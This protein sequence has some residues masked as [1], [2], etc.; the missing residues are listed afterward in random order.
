MT[1]IVVIIPVLVPPPLAPG[2]QAPS[3]NTKLRHIDEIKQRLI[4]KT[5]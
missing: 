4:R 2:T 5:K 1:V 3:N